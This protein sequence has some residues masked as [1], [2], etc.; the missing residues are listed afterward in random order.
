MKVINLN[1]NIAKEHEDFK[2][3]LF[4]LGFKDIIRPGMLATVGKFMNLKK[5]AKMRKIPLEDIIKTLKEKGYQVEGE[6]DE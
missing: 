3:I 2:E 6:N 5:G 4:E 1:D